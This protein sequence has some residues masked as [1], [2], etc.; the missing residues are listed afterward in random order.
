[1]ITAQ[2]GF[3]D[4]ALLLHLSAVR[5]NKSVLHVRYK[6]TH[7]PYTS[8]KGIQTMPSASQPHDL[9]SAVS[10]RPSAPNTV[11]CRRMECLHTPALHKVV[12]AG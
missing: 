9:P 6:H 11:G 2:L 5:V 12:L 1:M 10:K 7:C 8:I 3:S 4:G